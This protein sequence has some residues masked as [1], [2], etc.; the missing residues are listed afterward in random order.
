MPFGIAVAAIAP[1]SSE[2]ARIKIEY[3][4]LAL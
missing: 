4:R 1:E 2:E 3:A